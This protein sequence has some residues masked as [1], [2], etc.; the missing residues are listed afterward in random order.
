MTTVFIAFCNIYGTCSAVYLR[1]VFLEFAFFDA[2]GK[3][4]FGRILIW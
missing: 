1:F 2:S 4:L 3:F